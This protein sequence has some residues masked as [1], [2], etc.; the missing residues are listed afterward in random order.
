MGGGLS[1][2]LYSRTSFTKV[3]GVVCAALNTLL[4]FGNFGTSYRSSSTLK[5]LRVKFKEIFHL[6]KQLQDLH[7]NASQAIAAA[8]SLEKRQTRDI[9]GI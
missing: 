3:L 1:L 8:Q 2:L 7:R 5:D 6:Q 4:G 9:E